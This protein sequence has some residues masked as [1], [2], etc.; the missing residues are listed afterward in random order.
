[1]KHIGL[2]YLLLSSLPCYNILLL[3]SQSQKFL[4]RVCEQ[5]PTLNSNHCSF[6]CHHIKDFTTHVYQHRA[7]Y[8]S[9]RVLS[10][11][12]PSISILPC[13]NNIKLAALC[14]AHISPYSLQHIVCDIYSRVQQQKNTINS[15]I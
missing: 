12:N 7:R 9:R 2:I 15:N 10:A 11:V 14:A 13:I 3:C 6:L 1:M 4:S 8:M 5:H